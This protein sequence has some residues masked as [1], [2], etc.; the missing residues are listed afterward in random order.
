M[1]SRCFRTTM[2]EDVARQALRPQGEVVY[3]SVHIL[4]L[5]EG[6]EL[7]SSVSITGEALLSQF[8]CKPLRLGR[9]RL[10]NSQQQPERIH[11][12]RRIRLSENCY[13]MAK[14]FEKIGFYRIPCFITQGVEKKRSFLPPYTGKD[15]SKNWLIFFDSNVNQ[16]IKSL[17]SK[18]SSILSSVSKHFLLQSSSKQR[19]Q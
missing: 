15:F 14:F 10:N 8:S 1:R 16:P 11:K 18:F 5:T 12:D 4:T 17:Y 13:R 7:G 9:L 2:T 6:R 3:K 19:L